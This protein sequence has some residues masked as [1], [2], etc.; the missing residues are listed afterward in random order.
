M[1]SKLFLFILSYFLLVSCNQG[2]VQ[3]K[4]L[5]VLLDTYSFNDSLYNC[6]ITDSRFIE[7]C[8]LSHGLDS[9]SFN[10]ALDNY[11][12][13]KK[14][15]FVFYDAVDQ[16]IMESNIDNLFIYINRYNQKYNDTFLSRA[17]VD[18]GQLEEVLIMQQ[19]E[20]VAAWNNMWREYE[21]MESGLIGSYDLKCVRT[22][23]LSHLTSGID[24]SVYNALRFVVTDNGIMWRNYTT[25][26]DIRK[27][28][29][30]NSGMAPGSVL[31]NL[32]TLRSRMRGFWVSRAFERCADSGSGGG[33]TTT[34]GGGDKDDPELTPEQLLAR[35]LKFLKE[36]LG[37][38][39]NTI[40]LDPF[41]E[42]CKLNEQE[43]E[44]V[45][46][47]PFD[48]LKI[49]DNA[50]Y[51][52]DIVVEQYGMNG[53][54]DV[55]D[56]FRHCFFAALNSITCGSIMANRF[57]DAHEADPNQPAIEKT[58]D[59]HNNK[60]SYDLIRNDRDK[61]ITKDNLKDHVLKAVMDGELKYIKDG[62]LV[63]SSQ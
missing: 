37:L 30:V 9:L 60:V 48:A 61:I 58:M 26:Y 12:R 33:G 47:Y 4:N 51:V 8:D 23:L 43:L 14:A 35:R 21:S 57:G 20:I 41:Y 40:S 11:E 5:D 59:L 36:E 27:L 63:S 7:L 19:N 53:H 6:M 38:D 13:S 49:R 54:N 55:S 28:F 1:E 42:L 15:L 45:L 50:K 3:E 18:G 10:P 34:P 52:R 24:A 16:Y 2:T 25:I 29:V 17:I 46:K 62:S 39:V 31:D 56:A 44:L 22:K 32:N